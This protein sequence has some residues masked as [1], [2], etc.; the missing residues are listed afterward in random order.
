M[1]EQFKK[2]LEDLINVNGVDVL[3]DKPDYKLAEMVCKF[4]EW[5]KVEKKD[6][7][8]TLEWEKLF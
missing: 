1:T 8:I 5:F 2:Q 4:L 3:C 7:T 6:E